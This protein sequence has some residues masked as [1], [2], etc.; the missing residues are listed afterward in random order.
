[1]K[2]ESKQVQLASVNFKK[3]LKKWNDDKTKIIKDDIRTARKKLSH[4]LTLLEKYTIGY[5]D[6]KARKVKKTIGKLMLDLINDEYETKFENLSS[7]KKL[8]LALR[9]VGKL[10]KAEKKKSKL[11]SK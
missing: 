4:Q 5:E 8:S 6:E 11:V 9:K 10:R 2:T 1:M 3:L 7:R